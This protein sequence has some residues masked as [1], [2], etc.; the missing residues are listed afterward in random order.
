MCTHL[1][2]LLPQRLPQLLSDLPWQSQS[3]SPLGLC[4]SEWLLQVLV[5]RPHFV[6]PAAPERPAEPANL[7]A[8]RVHEPFH[9][10]ACRQKSR[11][12]ALVPVPMV[13][14]SADWT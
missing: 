3:A 10:Q 13:S 5:W 11:S 12:V 9:D 8:Y 2:L 14:H 7:S 6:D 4:L 1:P